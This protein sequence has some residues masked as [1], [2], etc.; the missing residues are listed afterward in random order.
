MC[1]FDGWDRRFDQRVD[2]PEGYIPKA[3]YFI[4]IK[5]GDRVLAVMATGS[6]LEQKE[7]MLR[8]IE[9]MQPLLD[10][11]AIALEHARLYTEA[12]QHARELIRLE[13]LSALGEMSAGLSHNL[14]NILSTIL[15]PAQILQETA[16]DP[17]QLQEIEDIVTSARRA[18]D[19]VHRLHRAVRGKEDV[20]LHPVSLNLAVQEAVQAT[21]PR[22]KDESESRGLAVEVITRLEEVPPIRGTPSELHDILINLLFNAVDAMPQGGT[23]TIATRV[24][25]EAVQLTVRDTGIGMDEETCRRVFEPFFTTKMD[26]G[27]GLGLATVYGTM[28]RWG[29]TLE[30]ESAPD[31][32]TVFTLQFPV[33]ADAP[34][35]EEKETQPRPARPSKILVVEDNERVGQMLGRLLGKDHEVELTLNGPEAL[36]NFAPGRCD[37]ALID[38]GMPGM[39]GDQVARKLRQVDPLLTTVLVTG[40]EL[41]EN[42]PRASVFDF[43]LQKPFVELNQVRDVV[44]RAIALRDARAGGES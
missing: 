34:A 23:I 36:A 39:P 42:D 6:D 32:G 24:L 33:W 10:Q 27:T 14:N 5:R 4:P 38:L 2:P 31:Q 1:V 43:Q 7:E 22:W 26:L 11:V 37:V 21:R 19:L 28:I 40:W 15:G 29:G 44:A 35:G 30:V 18:R 25:E 16:S 12:Q 3:S 8:R 9:A 13:R 41:Q 17:E 20:E